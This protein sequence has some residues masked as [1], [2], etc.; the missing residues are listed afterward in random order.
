MS[1]NSMHPVL[2]GGINAGSGNKPPW[3]VPAKAALGKFD[4][5]RSEQYFGTK[6]MQ[7]P[8]FF[9]IVTLLVSRCCSRSY[10]DG[11]FG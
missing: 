1:E 2:I 9:P 11:C 8:D 10:T 6:S 3:T 7:P 5:A 4:R